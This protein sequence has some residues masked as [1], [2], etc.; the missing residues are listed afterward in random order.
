MEKPTL[1]SAAIVVILCKTFTVLV[2]GF[3]LCL[4]I[5]IFSQWTHLQTPCIRAKY[6]VV[7]VFLITE[8]GLFGSPLLTL[9]YMV[10]HL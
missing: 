9:K 10:L 2:F 6:D 4:L 8:L 3:G 1:F 5:M 7:H